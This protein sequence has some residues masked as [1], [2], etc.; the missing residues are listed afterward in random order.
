VSP[1][2]FAV[3]ECTQCHE[4]NRTSTDNDHDEVNGYVYESRSCYSCHR[5]GEH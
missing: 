5:D 3:F 1:A 2:S 4:H